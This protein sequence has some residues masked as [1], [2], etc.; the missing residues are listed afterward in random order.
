MTLYFCSDKA[1]GEVA[2]GASVAPG[3]IGIGV[4]GLYIGET[5]ASGTSATD[6]NGVDMVVG[7]GVG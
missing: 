4:T 6:D 5:V 3:A 1:V 7:K 2:G